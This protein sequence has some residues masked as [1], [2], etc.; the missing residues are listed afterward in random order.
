M[1]SSKLVLIYIL[2]AGCLSLLDC[3]KNKPVIQPQPETRASAP[4]VEPPAANPAVE[5]IKVP[6]KTVIPV[7]EKKLAANG[8]LVNG[9]AA[10]DAAISIEDALGVYEEAK[11]AR[12]RGDF[13]GA[14][15]FLDEAYGMLIRLP[16]AADSPLIQEKDNLRLLI[17]QRIQ[18]INAARRNPTVE[19]HKSIPL[20]ENEWV[21]REIHSFIGPER[22]AFEEGYRRAG[23][24]KDWIV[25]ELRKAGL[26]EDLVWLPIV[27]SMFKPLALSSARALGIWQFIRTTG[28]NYDLNQDKFV[29][30]RR[31]PYKSTIAAIKYLEYL[32]SFFGDWTTALAAYNCGEGYV[33][34]IIN[35]QN[36]SY[37]DNF[38]DLFQRLPFQ[39]AR[40]VPRF[41]AVVR[42]IQNPDKYGM[43]LPEPYPPLQF[44]TVRIHHPAK[45][46]VFAAALGLEASELEFLNP[47]LRYQSTPDTPYDLRVPVGTGER[48]LAALPTLPKYVPPEYGMHKVKS[49]ETLSTIARRYGTSVQNLQKMNNLRGSLIRT[50]QTLRIPTRG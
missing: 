11:A 15:N 3:S 31:D 45:L 33:Q 34:R 47:E 12:E 30:E 32:H 44:D 9:Q 19:N 40:Y 16:I 36:I 2:L 29:D 21:L 20:T 42:I 38:W 24:Y 10:D 6:E 37:L 8:V 43:T 39:T 22:Q 28:L 48:L 35:S 46:S 1:K 7:E 50:G 18:E 25:G 5:V 27:E 17:A 14:V 26:P 23:F 13:E 4:A 49:G 41:I